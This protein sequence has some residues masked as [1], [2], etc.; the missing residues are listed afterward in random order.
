M[1][2]YLAL[3]VVLISL[4]SCL[5]EPDYIESDP[6]KQAAIDDS[7]IKAY[8]IKNNI[9]AVKD[10][11]QLYYQIINPGTG[12]TPTLSSSVA[13]NYTGTLLNGSQFDKNANVSFPLGNVIRGWQIGIP[14]IK[15]GGKILLFIPSALGYGMN[16]PAASIPSNSVLV[17]EVEL[18]G[19]K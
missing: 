14:L 12:E 10:S 11:S 8:I 7:L 17:F 2:K 6:A 18:L 9:P 5:K 19:V 3:F 16:S 4:S 1:K 15:P 13:V